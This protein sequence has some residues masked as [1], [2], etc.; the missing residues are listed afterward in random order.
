MT[1]GSDKER[2]ILHVD[3]DAFYASVEQ[4]DNPEFRRN[5]VLVGGTGPRGVVAACSYEARKFGIHSAMPMAEAI[6]RCPQ[7]ICVHPRMSHYKDV[8]RHIFSVLAEF[9]PEIEGLSLDEAFLDVTASLA[10]FGSI[11]T[12]GSFLRAEILKRTG[13]HASVGMAH[14]KYL[15][16]LASDAGKPRGFVPC[17]LACGISDRA[18]ASDR[19]CHAFRLRVYSEDT[20]L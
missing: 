15:A 17:D 18:P 9:T 7:A 20:V 3:M 5:P 14:N 19:H 2:C 16:K 8:S 10:L 12:I 6:R 1:T 4:R 11:E 13:L